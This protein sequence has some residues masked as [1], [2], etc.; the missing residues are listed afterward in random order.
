[1]STLS[2]HAHTLVESVWVFST[3]ILCWG[4]SPCLKEFCFSHVLWQLLRRFF[5]HVLW[6]ILRNKCSFDFFLLQM[7]INRQAMEGKNIHLIPH[8]SNPKFPFV[9]PFE[10]EPRE[11]K[12][13]E[14][15]RE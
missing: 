15:N 6:L 10:R 4:P 2:Q 3:V 7:P 14:K 5:S 13:G 9:I 1:M 11:L 12:R 8:H